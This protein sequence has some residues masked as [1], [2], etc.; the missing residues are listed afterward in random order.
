MNRSI[1]TAIERPTPSTTVSV[2]APASDPLR[3]HSAEGTRM[4]SFAGRFCLLVAL[5]ASFASRAFADDADDQF[6]QAANQYAAK[7]WDAAVTGFRDFRHQYPGHAKRGKAMYFEG[8]ALL[9]L[10]HHAEA[11][12]L[13]IDLLAEQPTGPYAKQ[14]LFRAAEAAVVSGKNAEAEIRLSQFQAQ[15]PGDKLNAHIMMFRGELALHIGDSASSANWY[16]ASLEKFPESPIADECRL[17]LAHVLELQKHSD[18]AE[19]QIHVVAEHDHSPW[20]EMALLQL[21]ARELSA[22]KP[23]AALEQ[24][25]AI[26][27]R[28][29][30]SSLLP[31]THLGCGKALFQLGHYSEAVSVLTPLVSN[32]E[33]AGDAKQWI[34]QAQKAEKQTKAAEKL[35]N[36]IEPTPPT[37]P[38]PTTT[39][40]RRDPKASVARAPIEPPPVES[41]ST[42]KESDPDDATITP[43]S[44]VVKHG[45]E[46]PS[47][48][49]KA[50]P[51][52]SAI[53]PTPSK[54]ISDEQA[55][56]RAEQN[57]R[58]SAIIRYQAADGMIRAGDYGRA[59]STLEMGDNSGD[60]PRSLANRYLLAIA[61]EGA[62]RNDEAL[63]T[64]DKLRNALDSKLRTLTEASNSD[65]SSDP[66]LAQVRADLGALKS[67]NDNVQLAVATSFVSREQYAD[68]IK[69]LEIYL[70]TPRKDVGGEKARTALVICLA[71]SHRADE[72]VRVLKELKDVYPDSRTIAATTF[73]VAEAAYAAADYTSAAKL[74][75]ELTD[76]S[77]SNEMI[78]KG[79]AGLGW[80]HYKSGD[81]DA[82][83]TVFGR[84]LDRYPIDSR[85][86]DVALARGQTLE[87]LG[88]DEAALAVVRQALKRYPKAK[89]LPE[90]MLAT[91]RLCDRLGHDEDAVLLYERIVREFPKNANIDAV[92]YGLAWSQHDLGHGDD[93]EKTFRRIYQLYPNSRFWDDASYRLAERA[94][95]RG[96]HDAAEALLSPLIDGDCPAP[97]REHALYLRAQMAI[98]V[99]KWTPAEQSLTKLVQDYPEGS[100]RLPAD[101][102]LA[103]VAYR[104]GDFA[105][106]QHRF[107]ELGARLT[108]HSDSWTAIIPLRRAQILSQ[109][110][111]WTQAQ[112]VA[113]SIARD[114][115]QFDE[116][117]EADYVIGRALAASENF[118]G[119]RAAFQRVVRSAAGGK[120]ET[121]AM[122]QWML[123]ETYFQEANFPLALREYLRVEVVY[124]YPRWQAAALL[125]AAKCYEKLGQANE[126]SELYARVLQSYPQ[127][128]FV[129]EA[130]KRLMDTKRK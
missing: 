38:S 17:R 41:A 20:S 35:R 30:N 80:C 106:A 40:S 122:A 86:P 34:A 5:C 111:Q 33:L 128:E 16:S 61:L 95:E 29:P 109:Q 24:Y 64:L 6:A 98:D 67:L 112:A 108:D 18:A 1:A 52:K 91:A 121:A 85:A 58:R 28:F 100:L 69:P 62:N 123:G 55:G 88:K 92:L 39:S 65:D 99:E 73:R 51:D 119:A 8:E 48:I 68:A 89:Q 101:F 107:D 113:E 130:S 23:Q 129:A 49:A 15:Y 37:P 26:E 44:I 76:E 53:G 25:E 125:Q 82:A 104:R 10:N 13:F 116:Q 4:S 77:N 47:S 36:T 103:E 120:T 42:P 84:F 11:Y 96:E 46:Q 70:A 43:K 19:E 7:H 50:A 71:Q 54:P 60:N 93:A 110:K 126:A 102:W 14:A 66:T 56:L 2:I 31:Q 81:N 124:T 22:G 118:D 74:Y 90:L 32:Q 63:D 114:Y 105:L 75:A 94:S 83:E 45:I 79:L 59:I 27:K 12:P 115:P 97:V 3:L 72:A 87:R 21:A 9:Q 117:H 57:R 127:T 78:A